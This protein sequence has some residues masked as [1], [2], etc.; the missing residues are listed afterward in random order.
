[1]AV[2][3]DDRPASV[4]H[5]PLMT[6]HTSTSVRRPSGARSLRA[7]IA[8]AYVSGAALI[9]D[10]VTI[11]VI[12]RSFDPLDSALF[13]VGFAGMLLTTLALS[14]FLTRT[15]T[16][17]NRAITAVGIFLAV[18]I[19]LGVI[20]F[21]FDQFG[22]HVFSAGNKGLHGEWSFFSIGV[23]L[24]VIGGW[25]QRRETVGSTPETGPAGRTG[26]SR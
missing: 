5:D 7:T 26:L 24:V 21:A 10:T 17:V 15:R 8:L 16:G 23:A 18:G 2:S 11:A 25:A 9:I 3:G 4:Q 6:I 13:L 12:N 19:A 22:R 1:M 14:L 20:S